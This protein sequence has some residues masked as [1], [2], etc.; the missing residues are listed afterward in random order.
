MSD[1]EL[2]Q[3]CIKDLGTISI[4][5]V[6]LEQIAIPIYNVRQNLIALRQSIE[7]QNNAKASEDSKKPEELHD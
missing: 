3:K 6:L 1:I 2:L 5:T 7:E 4:P